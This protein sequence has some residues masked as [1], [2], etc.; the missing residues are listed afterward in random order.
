VSVEAAAGGRA[1]LRPAG[2]GADRHRADELE[3]AL[4]GIFPGGFT[5][6]ERR[7]GP[8]RSTFPLEELAVET[9]SGVE[10]LVWKDLSRGG[11]AGAAWRG[12]PQPLR[13]P[14]REIA[15]YRDRLEGAELAAPALR[16]AV[17]D[18]RAGRYW[19]FLE[20]VEGVPLWQI[21]EP[22]TWEESARWLAR[23]HTRF[24]AEPASL[25]L[26]DA[27]APRFWIDRARR[28]LPAG[29]LDGRDLAG[30]ERSAARAALRL[31]Q[32]P[33]TLLHGDFHPSNVLVEES[34]R[35]RA[36]DWESSAAGPGALDLA[37]LASGLWTL[38]ER[39]ALIAAYGEELQRAGL[40][41]PDRAE[42]ARAV[43][44]GR[45]LFAVRWLGWARAWTPPPHQVHD[46]LE[47]A[48]TLAREIGP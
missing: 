9:D 44:L 42:L 31:A 29:A 22:E 2:G 39:A 18:A 16:G 26:H 19:L 3:R 43:D 46:W 48:F 41:P 14:R 27:L 25:P 30:L 47:T 23:L 15:V 24:A 10:W 7:P 21:G 36:V 20:R 33:A 4:G 6:L 17:A 35:I 1:R 8:Y 37:A 34:G 11:A 5:L 32:Q 40:E 13:D 45:L 38:E 12:R 28:F